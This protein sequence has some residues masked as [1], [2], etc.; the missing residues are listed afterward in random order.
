MKKRRVYFEDGEIVEVMSG[1][2][3][4]KRVVKNHSEPDMRMWFRD[5]P[6]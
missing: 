3:H 2:A 5:C 6:E 4:F 1:K